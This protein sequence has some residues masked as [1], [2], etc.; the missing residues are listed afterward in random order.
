MP[1]TRQ[2][3]SAIWLS[4]K[5]HAYQ[6]VRAEA[7]FI[8]GVQVEFMH[9][10][11]ELKAFLRK[12]RVSVIIISDDC[13]DAFLETYFK[14]LVALPDTAGA[15]LILDQTCAHAGTA[16]LALANGFRDIL[17]A[18]LDPQEWLSRFMFSAAVSPFRL[19]TPHCQLALNQHGSLEIPACL[20]SISGS[21]LRIESRLQ[22]E[23]GSKVSLRGEFPLL[24]GKE[25]ISGTVLSTDTKK[26]LHKL[27]HSLELELDL[28]DPA[29]K[30]LSI[31]VA[32]MQQ[33]ITFH[34]KRIFVVI[35]HSETRFQVLENF[36]KEGHIVRCAINR[37]SIYEY[38]KFFSPELVVIESRFCRDE[39][40]VLFEKLIENISPDVLVAIIGD[41]KDH[42]DIVATFTANKFKFIS[43]DFSDYQSL[44]GE[45]SPNP[46]PSG[47]VDLPTTHPLVPLTI[48]APIVLSR[49]H[50]QVGEFRSNLLISNFSLARLHSAEITKTMGRSPILKITAVS[51]SQIIAVKD[52]GKATPLSCKYM[53]Y[54]ADLTT[55][56]RSLLNSYLSREFFNELSRFGRVPEEIRPDVNL[57]STPDSLPNLRESDPYKAD[58]IEEKYSTYIPSPAVSKPFVVPKWIQAILLLIGVGLFIW[59]AM[60]IGFVQMETVGDK[61][62][63]PF[64]NFKKQKELERQGLAP[65]PGTPTTSPFDT[66]TPPGDSPQNPESEDQT[67]LRSETNLEK[68]KPKEQTP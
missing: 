38:P 32:R 5:I 63:K 23:P 37:S 57:S 26:L 9:T 4:T 30:E 18:T 7:L 10:M 42:L 8:R 58:I 12:K 66:A 52:E 3:S 24:L 22:A 11:A 50:P 60:T 20:V 29:R 53:F 21:T 55:S 31:I 59:A 41:E 34:P 19:N 17:P 65:L 45:V 43:R 1:P 67:R 2:H 48:V 14:P 61:Y 51:Q 6:K 15:R 16:A 28:D 27:S 35:S 46:H 64:V 25:V 40:H 44:L 36:Q 47:R 33:Q 68:E 54:F 39:N 62:S 13:E 56:E 49:L